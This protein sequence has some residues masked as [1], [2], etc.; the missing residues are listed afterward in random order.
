MSAVTERAITL[1]MMASVVSR[2]LVVRPARIAAELLALT[3]QCDSVP[4]GAMVRADYLEVCCERSNAD[5][6]LI[7]NAS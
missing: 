2:E 4:K 5:A 7:R 3:S 6:E 1:R